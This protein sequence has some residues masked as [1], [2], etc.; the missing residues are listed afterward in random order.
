M[1]FSILN[2]ITC[3]RLWIAIWR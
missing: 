1:F 2:Y 3:T